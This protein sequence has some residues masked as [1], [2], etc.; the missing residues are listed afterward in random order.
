MFILIIFITSIQMIFMIS[1]RTL[2]GLFQ[3]DKQPDLVSKRPSI[4]TAILAIFG[5]IL[6]GYGY[7]LSGRMV[8]EQLAV[9]ALLVMASTITGTYILFRVTISWC[10]YWFRKRKKDT[11]AFTTAFRL[12]R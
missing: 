9:N 6:I 8:D 12:L 4:L 10:L 7:E 11:W 5:V 3:A 2:L 1:R